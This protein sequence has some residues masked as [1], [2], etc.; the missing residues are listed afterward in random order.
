MIM[1]KN[2]T[3][4]IIGGRVAKDNGRIFAHVSFGKIVNEFAKHYK[5]ILLCTPLNESR[6]FEDD[7]ILEENV[8]LRSQPNWKSTID[9][10]KHLS[11]IKRSYKD[12]ISEADHVFIRGNPVAATL[13]LYRQCKQKDKPVCH[14]IVGN[15][16]ALLRSHNR[17]GIIKDTLGLV[18]VWQWE[19]KL[20]LGQRLSN[21]ILICNGQELANRYASENTFATI[22]TTLTKEDFY[23]RKDTCLNDS[24]NILCLCYIRPEKGIEYLIEAIGRFKA[25]RSI[26]LMIAGNRDR[27]TKYQKKLDAFV[28]HF[29]LENRVKWLGHVRYDSIHDLMIRSDIFALPTLSEGTPRVLVEARSKGLPI[30]TTNVGGI[31]YSVKNGHDGI[32]V[33]P[34][35]PVS[36]HKGIDSLINNGSLRRRLIRNGYARVKDLTIDKFVGYVIRCLQNHK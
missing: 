2:K 18:Y 31:P 7:Y 19:K 13:S 10:F 4:T 1:L 21:G 22:S 16:L 11:G 28:Q 14:W 26:N 5:Q 24:V 25:K 30:V 32:L 3:L 29:K 27:Y 34:K 36:L 12:A 15:P 8:K 9:S 23:Y 35:D 17:D 33:P 20:I 6:S